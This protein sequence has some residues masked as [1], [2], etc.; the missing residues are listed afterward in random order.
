MGRGE[1]PAQMSCTT[2][3]V[4]PKNRPAPCKSLYQTVVYPCPFNLSLSKCHLSRSG[5]ATHTLSS[6]ATHNVLP[7]QS[8]C[9]QH[10]WLQK[11][12][13]WCLCPSSASQEKNSLIITIWVLPSYQ[14]PLTIVNS[15]EKG[16]NESELVQTSPSPP[17]GLQT[18]SVVLCGSQLAID[19]KP[20]RKISHVNSPRMHNKFNFSVFYY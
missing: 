13:H 18:H 17:Q 19:S 7:M 8:R 12:L 6:S 14:T 10:H 3:W 16:S 11:G 1:T 2:K 20:N 15:M 9:L 4:S 5:C